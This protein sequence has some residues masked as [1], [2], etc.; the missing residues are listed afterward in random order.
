MKFW[1]DK[2]VLG[3]KFYKIFYAKTSLLGLNEIL[4]VICSGGTEKRYT[5]CTDLFAFL[6]SAKLKTHTLIKNLMKASKVHVPITCASNFSCALRFP[7]PN[8]FF[9]IYSR[10]RPRNWFHCVLMTAIRTRLKSFAI[11]P[12]VNHLATSHLNAK[13]W[14]VWQPWGSL[15]PAMVWTQH[16]HQSKTAPE[17]LTF[18][19]FRFSV[20]H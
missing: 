6:I 17:I 14:S 11:D 3:F 2:V 10:M 20:V 18:A 19:L 9:M 7:L 13:T 8:E 5:F 16:Q 12:A 15:S 4:T 1:R